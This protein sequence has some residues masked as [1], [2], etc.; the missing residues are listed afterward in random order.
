MFQISLIII[1][2]YFYMKQTTHAFKESEVNESRRGSQLSLYIRVLM[3]ACLL[4]SVHILVFW[5]FP[6]NG[7]K[8]GIGHYYC[9]DLYDSE[10]CNNFEINFFLKGFYIL[11]LAYL[12]FAA[13][14]IRYGFP[15]FKRHALPL[16]REVSTPSLFIFKVYRNAPFFIEIRTLLDWIFTGTSL[17]LYQ[18]LKFEDIYAQLFINK[19]V[20]KSLDEKP[21]GDPIEKCEKCYMGIA[22]LV[23]II[24]VIL[25]PLIIFSTLNPIIE[26]NQVTSAGITISILFDN[27]AFKIFSINTAEKINTI[28][29]TEWMENNFNE[30]SE[31]TTTDIDI[32]QNISMP[33]FSD[34]VWDISPPS[35]EQ[36]CEFVNSNSSLYSLKVD[37]KFSR[38]YPENNKKIEFDTINLIQD[39]IIAKFGKMVCENTL[40]GPVTAGYRKLDWDNNTT[41]NTMAIELP[42]A[43][44]QLIRL[45]SN[46]N[47]L[48]PVIISQNLFD[49]TLILNYSDHPRGGYWTAKMRD[50]N[51]QNIGIRLF[52]ISDRFSKITLNYSII[53]FYISIVFAV[54]TILKYISIGSGSNLN[55]TDMKKTSH[56]ETLCAGVYVSRMIGDIPKEEELYYELIEILR[57]PE[58]TKML[59]GPSSIKPKTD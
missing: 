24:I 41:N 25:A 27:R 3:H 58:I 42:F 38:K 21:L 15:S 55:F 18:W 45:P 53:T 17:N 10:R 36:L 8:S 49:D 22:S 37:Y 48:A 32:M 44:K 50:K 35:L 6:M 1:E 11:Y 31:L 9:K 29:E 57:S 28:N 33:Q 2:R 14:Q 59:T 56:L 16:M 43:I 13:L 19:C 20:Q 30:N 4:I 26:F 46:G 5:Y 47:Y 52:T 51:G 39:D 7:N 23:L 40:L 34:T 12:I 54:G